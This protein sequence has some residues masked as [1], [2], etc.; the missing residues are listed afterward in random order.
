VITQLGY[1]N[2]QA[3]KIKLDNVPEPDLAKVA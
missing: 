2:V 1:R 3:R